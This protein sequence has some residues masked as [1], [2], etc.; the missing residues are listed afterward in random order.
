MEK[1][2]SLRFFQYEYWGGVSSVSKKSFWINPSI[3]NVLKVTISPSIKEKLSNV[4]EINKLC[5]SKKLPDWCK[6]NTIL[7]IGK[8]IPEEYYIKFFCEKNNWTID[9][10]ISKEFDDITKDIYR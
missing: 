5:D 3:L 6:K 2:Y 10:P 7:S 4:S 9:K 1:Q 8:E